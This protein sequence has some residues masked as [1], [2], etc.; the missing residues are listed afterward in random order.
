MTAMASPSARRMV[1]VRQHLLA[2]RMGLF[3][4]FGAIVVAGCG[5]AAV[6]PPATASSR[7]AVDH[8]SGPPAGPV[9]RDPARGRFLDGE[10]CPLASYPGVPT[11]S[12]CI[13]YAAGHF[14]GDGRRDTL[15]VYA[16]PLDRQGFARAWHARITLHSGRAVVAALG[17]PGHGIGLGENLWVMGAVNADGDG[18]DEAIVRVNGG[19]S[20]DLLG[21]FLLRNGHLIEARKASGGPFVFVFGSDVNFGSGGGCRKAGG[22][23]ELVDAGAWI[24]RKRWHWMETYYR[25]QG[26]QVTPVRSLRGTT[27]P[28]GT[29]RYEAFRCGEVD[30]NGVAT[31]ESCTLLGNPTWK[32][33]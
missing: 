2:R 3:A 30:L 32:P 29:G 19:A 1:P 12:G 18:A 24:K 23:M 16:H 15:V 4:A 28:R 11:G 25:W 22:R 5:Q 8:R 6:V 7:P 33:I 9:P 10:P 20:T 17:R 14:E 21:I 27:T 31:R 13:S 26:T